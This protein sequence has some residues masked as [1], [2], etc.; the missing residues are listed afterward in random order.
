MPPSAREV[1]S[2]Y[3]AEGVRA[4]RDVAFYRSRIAGGRLPPLRKIT[5]ILKYVRRIFV[6]EGF[7][8]PFVC[9]RCGGSKPPPY[10]FAIIL[11]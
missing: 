1:P 3:E 5:I 2:A 8:F 11:K 4:T 7:P 10:G 9:R 6:G